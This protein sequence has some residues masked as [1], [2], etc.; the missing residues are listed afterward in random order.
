MR[1]GDGARSLA[2]LDAEDA[3][4]FLRAGDRVARCLAGSY[5]LVRSGAPI[6]ETAF[7]VL[8]QG[9]YYGGPRWGGALEPLGDALLPGFPAQTYA[10]VEARSHARH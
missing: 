4:P 5:V 6:S 2:P 7:L 8:R 10:W 1:G 3:L 9:G